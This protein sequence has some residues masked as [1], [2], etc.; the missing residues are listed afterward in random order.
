MRRSL[1]VSRTSSSRIRRAMS[2]SRSAKEGSRGVAGFS[3]RAAYRPSPAR[4][5][6]LQV[7]VIAN[8]LYI[9]K[10]LKE[11]P[12]HCLDAHSRLV[13]LRRV[14]WQNR[15]ERKPRPTLMGGRAR[16]VGL[17]ACPVQLARNSIQYPLPTL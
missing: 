3:M 2:G 12:P 13:K 4:A 7:D 17:R 14:R 11:V 9:P 15:A 8:E 10:T 1:M 16:G 6:A 5:T